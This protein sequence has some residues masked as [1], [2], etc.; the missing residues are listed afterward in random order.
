MAL[1]GGTGKG[2]WCGD[3]N[4]FRK[5]LL[6]YVCREVAVN[7]AGGSVSGGGRA[8]MR[9]YDGFD[10]AAFQQMMVDVFYPPNNSFLTHH[11]DACITNCWANWDLCTMA[12]IMAIGILTDEAAKYDQ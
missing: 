2:V 10:L 6:P 5:R 12:S 11:S 8:V 7:Q 1:L 9:D 3:G 4:S